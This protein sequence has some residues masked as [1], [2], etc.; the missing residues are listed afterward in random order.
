MIWF[1][2]LDWKG[3]VFKRWRFGKKEPPFLVGAAIFLSFSVL[4]VEETRRGQV[5]SLKM[6]QV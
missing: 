2:G 5:I 1:L 4:L 6:L 3:S